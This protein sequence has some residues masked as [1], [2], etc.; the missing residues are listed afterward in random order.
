MTAHRLPYDLYKMRAIDDP[1]DAGTIR[2]T[3]RSHVHVPLISS[4]AETRTL[5]APDKEGL[6]VTLSMQTDG[7]DITLTVTGNYDEAGSSTVTFD[8]TGEYIKFCSVR[9][10]SNFV[11]RVL[12]YDGVAGPSLD[13]GTL[14]IDALT[15]SGA[16]T[17]S[18]AATFAG[19]VDHSGTRIDPECVQP[20]AAYTLTASVDAGKTF[21][22]G[23][24][25]RKFTLPLAAAGNDGVAFTFVNGR[26]ATAASV[27][28]ELWVDPVSADK[29]NGGTSGIGLYLLG[30]IDTLGDHL[31]LKSDGSGWWTTSRFA[32]TASA[33]QAATGA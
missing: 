15:V 24:L 31:T 17:L 28:L 27:S 1:G 23:S 13:L 26:A 30:S 12:G 9:E 29:I 8:N 5:A 25:C 32:N 14:T 21:V 16:T 2:M 22:A 4:G 20:T 33:W 19:Q 18:G 6:E 7:G 10:G 3:G 11:W